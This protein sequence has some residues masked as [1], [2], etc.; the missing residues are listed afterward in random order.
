MML[1]LGLL[2][3]V[4]LIQT[5]LAEEVYV[6][7]GATPDSDHSCGNRSSPCPTLEAALNHTA[8]QSV[9]VQVLSRTLTLSHQIV[10]E[11]STAFHLRGSDSGGTLIT[12]SGSS[13][14]QPGLVLVG[15]DNVTISSVN[16]TSC[17]TTKTYE[18][19]HD[20][21]YE[22]MAAIHLQCQCHR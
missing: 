16:F 22:Y 4:V 7:S 2:L 5:G 9:S 6:D 14:T 1:H 21:K 13:G 8:L 3:F 12:C 17:G 19:E 11:N 20:T 18:I 10:L 15:L